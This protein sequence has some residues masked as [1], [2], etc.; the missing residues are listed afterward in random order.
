MT[1]DY[2]TSPGRHLEQFGTCH[3][4]NA[5]QWPHMVCFVVSWLD[6]IV[7]NPLE[8]AYLVSLSVFYHVWIVLFECD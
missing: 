5:L 3:L 2:T 6:S 8:K 7:K 4:I 1:P